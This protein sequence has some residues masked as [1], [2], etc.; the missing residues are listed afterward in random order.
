M[1]F[2]QNLELL[3]NR[4]KEF[5]QQ[6]QHTHVSPLHLLLALL[7]TPECK[8][9]KHLENQQ[10]PIQKLSDY[11]SHN[12]LN[13][14]PYGTPTGNFNSRSKF[15]LSQSAQIARQMGSSY[16]RTEHL[17]LGLLTDQVLAREVYPVVGI[18]SEKLTHSILAQYGLQEEMVGAR[19][20]TPQSREFAEV[21]VSLNE[22]ARKGKLDPVIGRDRETRRAMQILGRRRKN[23]PVL[24]GDAGV[25]KT[26][27]AEGIAQSIVKRT[28][29]PQLLDKEIFLWDVTSLVSNTVFRGQLEGRLK[30]I[31]DHVRNNPRIILFIDEIHLIVGAGNSIGGLDVSN[32]MKAALSRGE[33]RVIGATTEDEYNKTIA[34]DSALERRF[35]PVRVEEPPDEDVL[36]ILQGSLPGYEAHHNVQYTPEAVTAALQLSKRYIPHRQLPDKALDVLDEAGSAVRMTPPQS[37]TRLDQDIA[38]LN[39]EKVMAATQERFND[40]QVLLARVRHLKAQRNKLLRQQTQTRPATEDH[41]RAAVSVISRIPLERLTAGDKRSALLV[42][43]ELGREIIGQRPAIA[44]VTRYIRRSRTRLNDPRKPLGGILLLGPTGVGKTLLAKRLA[45]HM[46]GSE[47]GLIALDMSEYMERQSASRLIGAP[48]GYK[49]YDD[50]KTLVERVRRQPYAVVLFDEIEKAHHQVWNV[51]LQILEEGRLTDGQG[52]TASFRD[53]LVLLTSNIGYEHFRRKSIGFNHTADDTKDAVL[54]AAKKEFRPE[55]LNR[56]DDIVVFDPLTLEDCRQIIDLEVERIRQRT[57]YISLTLS[58][59]LREEI[60][61]EGFSEE[62]GARP[63]KRTLERLVTD[64]ISDALLR[65]EITDTGKVLATYTGTDGVVIRQSGSETHCA[66]QAASVPA[67]I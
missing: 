55:F 61:K 8:G 10:A 31:L 45:V 26:A 13:H 58:P 43:D 47:E 32:M 22:L 15:V 11:I 54:G 34:K 29:P 3:L 30:A 46:S 57:K 41:V 18:R 16:T 62:Y 17:L 4:A 19:E 50:Q 44:T 65:E 25:G 53:T 51:L 24:I 36:A 14:E 2:S 66:E 6:L 37:V 9:Y 12:R 59:A 23:N 1:Q 28:C 49:G 63:L 67:V 48:P 33:A 52:R 5:A 7:K 42:Q 56:I 60:L 38:R 39:E 35:Q 40:A 20:S 27:I 64:P 21:C